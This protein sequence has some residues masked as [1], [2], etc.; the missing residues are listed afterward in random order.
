L[1]VNVDDNKKLN[2]NHHHGA[3]RADYFHL[4]FEAN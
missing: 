2:N 3:D 4:H 1:L